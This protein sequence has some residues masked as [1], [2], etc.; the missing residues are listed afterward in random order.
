[1]A[2]FFAALSFYLD[3][4]LSLLTVCFL[5]FLTSDTEK[6]A[7]IISEH[8]SCVL[9][10]YL[11]STLLI[12]MPVPSPLT[13][14]SK[15]VPPIE[16]CQ[17]ISKALMQ[18]MLTDMHWEGLGLSIRMMLTVHLVAGLQSKSVTGTLY[19][20]HPVASIWTHILN[21]CPVY[22]LIRAMSATCFAAY[23]FTHRELLSPV[24]C[25][26]W[27]VLCTCIRTPMT[28]CDDV[29][30]WCKR[31]CGPCSGGTIIFTVTRHMCLV[32]NSKCSTTY[33][34]VLKLTTTVMSLVCNQ[35]HS[36]NMSSFAYFIISGQ[37][38]P[39]SAH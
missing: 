39:P 27:H 36:S 31:V 30:V 24:T 15:T 23:I 6:Q 4:V 11:K 8:T 18:I 26:T 20:W 7:L 33:L 9:I 28:L 17:L 35:Q 19:C 21:K 13:L 32:A 1:M 29:V 38:W 14:I 22:R 2:L 3:T 10:W 16:S 37:P 12:C 25:H 34:Y 5:K